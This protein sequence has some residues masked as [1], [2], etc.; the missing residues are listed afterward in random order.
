MKLIKIINSQLHLTD[1]QIHQIQNEISLEETSSFLFRLN[2][3]LKLIL[4]QNGILQSIVCQN[5]QTM[6]QFGLAFRITDNS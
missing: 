3:V 6:I 5:N 4:L 1:V 2:L